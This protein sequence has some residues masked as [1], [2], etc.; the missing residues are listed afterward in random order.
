MIAEA[1]TVAIF[2]A[3]S[4]QPPETYPLKRTPLNLI[5][6]KD[7]D[8]GKAKMVIGHIED[9]PSTRLLAQDPEFPEYGSIELVFTAD[10]VELRQWV[11]VDDLGAATTVIL[12]EMIKGEDLKPG[13]FDIRGE[14]EQRAN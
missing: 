11:I 6:A 2:D 10:P 13:I 14:T 12:G 8:L 9:G 7:I 3:K 5:L 1:Q 4:N